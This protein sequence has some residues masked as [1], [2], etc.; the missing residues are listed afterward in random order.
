[1]P[2]AVTHFT[3]GCGT[4][5]ATHLRMGPV[6]PNGVTKLSLDLSTVDWIGSI[7]VITAEARQVNK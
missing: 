4:P 1:M 6:C 7:A 2:S 5:N 3:S